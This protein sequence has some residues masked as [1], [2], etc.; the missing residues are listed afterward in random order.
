MKIARFLLVVPVVLVAACSDATGPERA[1]RATVVSPA[2]M[3][4][5]N[6]GSAIGS[7]LSVPE[8]STKM[9]GPKS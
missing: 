1:D 3:G 6:N 2:S 4:P 9:P 7:G 5:L 8:D